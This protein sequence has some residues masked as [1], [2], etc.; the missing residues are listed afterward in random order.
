[1]WDRS[2]IKC[3]NV[4]DSTRKPMFKFHHQCL[5]PGASTKMDGSP[6]T[7]RRLDLPKSA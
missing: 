3:I 2:K 5:I 7:V 6:A 4:F 1:M